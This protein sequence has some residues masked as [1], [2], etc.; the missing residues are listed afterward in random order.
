MCVISGCT[1]GAKLA[2]RGLCWNHYQRLRRTGNAGP[3]GHVVAP[4]IWL[5][6][7]RSDGPGACWPWL[8]G[9]CGSGY[10]HMSRPRETRQTYVHRHIYEKTHGPIPAG[11]TVDHVCFN[12]L[13][14]N[15][16]HL[17]LLSLSQNIKSRNPSV[18]RR[19]R[20]RRPRTCPHRIDGL[21][22]ADLVYVTPNGRRCR[23]C[24]SDYHAEWQ[25]KRLIEVRHERSGAKLS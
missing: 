13:C 19:S 10:G 9:L 16:A 8:G 2:A 24:A 14:C 20:C 1:T 7:D 23:R 12:T 17:R 4:D 3:A 15:P 25:R 18:A 5:K 6:I 22:P 21:L 11:L